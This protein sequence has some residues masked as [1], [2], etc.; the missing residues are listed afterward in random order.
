[1][2]GLNKVILI[3]NLGKDPEVR[4]IDSGVKVASFPLATTESYKNKAGEK[5]ETT[6]WHNIVVWRGL[7]EI[8]EKYLHKGKK[9]YIE[10][11]IR[12][13]SYNDK[14]GVKKYITEII[15]DNMLLL[16]APPDKRENDSQE[17]KPENDTSN[18]TSPPADDLPF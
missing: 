15:C 7:A 6:E 10:G 8:A 3:G 16:G 17:P 14:D 13:R 4:T 5:V 12:T 2:A 1:M 9:A 11:R 18:D